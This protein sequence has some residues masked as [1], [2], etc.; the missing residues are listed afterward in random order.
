M[1]TGFGEKDTETKVKIYQYFLGDLN[2]EI[3]S[4]PYKQRKIA[5]EAYREITSSK[6]F[7]QAIS[8]LVNETRLNKDSSA[9]ARHNVLAREL[10]ER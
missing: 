5:L 3:Q 2:R 6:T 8:K 9:G 7:Q 4:L 1:I 10:Q